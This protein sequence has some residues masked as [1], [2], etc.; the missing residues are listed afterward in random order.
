MKFVTTL[1]KISEEEFK[2][3]EHPR[4][5]DGKFTSKGGGVGKKT[6]VS[7]DKKTS[8]ADRIEN[9]KN[10]H[11]I[12]RMLKAGVQPNEM[13][14]QLAELDKKMEEQSNVKTER[15]F[16]HDFGDGQGELKF[17][18]TPEY[19]KALIEHDKLYD[20]VSKKEEDEYRKS[21]GWKK[22]DPFRWTPHNDNPDSAE[23]G[24]GS[25][26]TYKH[27]KEEE[28]DVMMRRWWNDGMDRKE[29]EDRY[30]YFHAKNIPY[31]NEDG[32]TPQELEEEMEEDRSD[33]S[34]YFFFTD[35][36]TGKDFRGKGMT[37]AEIKKRAEH[38]SIGSFTRLNEDGSKEIHIEY[39]WA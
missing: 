7:K 27:L 4:T 39:E 12:S 18:G 5:G 28:I 14:L 30:D 9:V 3:E 13:D 38:S 10:D 37:K 15:T 19:E 22:G 25:N 16:K 29:R 33:V 32:K 34:D 11:F 1:R 23:D 20:E 6:K 8:N 21:Y 36:K 35:K 24:Y 2:E 26:Y 17:T 31:L